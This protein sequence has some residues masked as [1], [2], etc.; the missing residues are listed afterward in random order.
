MCYPRQKKVELT[1]TRMVITD[2]A[3]GN[4]HA[5][6]RFNKDTI[7]LPLQPLLPEIK[8]IGKNK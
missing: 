5:C 3:T 8:R 4:R 7:N 2:L 6:S 1:K